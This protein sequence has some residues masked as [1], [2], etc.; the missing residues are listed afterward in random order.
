MIEC[1]ESPPDNFNPKI[2]TSAVYV[3]CQGSYLF[4]ETNSHKALADQWGVPAG[5]HET[6]ETPLAAAVRE[7]EEEAGIKVRNLVSMGT[8]YFRK[9]DLDFI[10][11][12]YF[13]QFDK[14]PKVQLS[15]EHKNF[16][17]VSVDE[18]KDLR[19]IAGAD[20]ALDFVHE[21]LIDFKR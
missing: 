20:A 10:Y 3:E 17:W 11:H 2:E 12:T 9:Q 19:L 5:K 18:A 15:D 6:D 21:K 13:I 7:L 16:K 4:L 8:L 1:F 14:F